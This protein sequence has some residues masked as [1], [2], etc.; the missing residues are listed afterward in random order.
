VPQALALKIYSEINA[1]ACGGLLPPE[2]ELRWC[3]KLKSTA[4]RTPQWSDAPAAGGARRARIELATTVLIDEK[5]LRNTLAHEICHVAAWL[6]E[7]TMKPAHGAA[8][9]KWARH[10]E[11]VRPHCCSTVILKA[12][13]AEQFCGSTSRFGAGVN[14]QSSSSARR[15][16]C[17]SSNCLPC[18]HEAALRRT[19]GLCARCLLTRMHFLLLGDPFCKLV[20]RPALG[21][22][23]FTPGVCRILR[24][25]ASLQC[26]QCMVL[27][28]GSP[29][30]AQ[31]PLSLCW[32]RCRNVRLA[33]LAA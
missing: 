16:P 20:G 4:G 14:S 33:A 21:K 7:A 1:Y 5:R 2:L 9:K 32:A 17:P 28:S 10:I 15:T 29:S 23:R 8:F 13:C 31:V 24:Q 25:S 30:D 12:S 26:E 3:P 6:L 18:C 19:A 27:S 22:G 11:Q